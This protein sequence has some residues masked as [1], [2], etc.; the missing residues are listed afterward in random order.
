MR[1]KQ[2]IA[3]VLS[4]FVIIGMIFVSNLFFCG[5]NEEAQVSF[6]GRGA[7]ALNLMS[8]NTK[9]VIS[10]NYANGICEFVYDGKEHCLDVSITSDQELIFYR[11]IDNRTI[12]ILNKFIYVGEYYVRVCARANQTFDEPDP[13]SLIVRVLPCELLSESSGAVGAIT[14]KNDDGFCLGGYSATDIPKKQKRAA[15]RAVKNKL[16]YE[17]NVIEIFKVLPENVDGRNTWV[18]V[19]I[20]LPK[21][22][23]NMKNFRFFEYTSSGELKELAYILNPNSFDIG[24]IAIDSIVVISADKLHP[25]LWIWLLISV[26]SFVG[27]A[28]AIYL[29]VPRK[30][31]FFV[32]GKKVY[33]VKLGR[34]QGFTLRDGLEN[35]EW[36]VDKNLTTKAESFGVKETSKN[37]YAKIKI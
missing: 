35:Y 28:G 33:V 3:L 5:K 25:Y 14:I 17:E 1:K 12:E 31:N 4:I 29:L 26:L 10:S 24:E 18:D 20:G 11:V 21:N 6:D 32:G 15:R 8:D 22:F 36:F 16:S 19:S 2:K 23:S 7:A 27:M 30:I 34:R 9:P 13:L 37:Y